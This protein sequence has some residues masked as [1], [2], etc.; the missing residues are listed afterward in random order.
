MTAA[1]S[2]IAIS[3]GTALTLIGFAPPLHAQNPN[4]ATITLA[5][6]NGVCTE[7]IT[8]NDPNAPGTVRAKRGTA[9]QWRVVNNC[10]ADTSVGLDD[11]RIKGGDPNSPFTTNGKG[12]CTAKPGQQCNIT[13]SIRGNAGAGT[14]S[15][16]ISVNGSAVDPDLIIEM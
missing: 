5:M 14:Y 12:G 16:A 11:W 7:T 13:L 1:R 10:S 15:Y 3:I 8:G 6:S 4:R 2:L 9:V